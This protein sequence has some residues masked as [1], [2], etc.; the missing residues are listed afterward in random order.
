MPTNIDVTPWDG[1]TFAESLFILV[2]ITPQQGLEAFFD[3]K[4]FTILKDDVSEVMRN[5]EDNKCIINL[6]SGLSHEIEF[7]PDHPINPI[8]VKIG[9]VQPQSNEEMRNLLMAIVA[10]RYTP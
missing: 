1:A 7:Q 3:Y 5:T 10:P 2:S 4:D 8:I 9:G 6:E